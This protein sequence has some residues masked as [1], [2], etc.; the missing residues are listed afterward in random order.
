MTLTTVLSAQVTYSGLKG[1]LHVYDADTIYPGLLYFNAVYSGFTKKDTELKN[2]I[3]DNTLNIAL[4]FGLSHSFEFF[5]HFVPYQDDQIGYWGP[6][7]DSRLGLKFHA[8]APKGA[9]FYF[10]MFAYANFPTGYRHNLMFEPF[11]TDKKGW[12]LGGIG[13]FDLKDRSNTLPVKF[14]INIGYRDHD[15][16]DRYFTDKKD[17]FVGGLGIKFPV[18]SSILYSEFTGRIFINNLEHVDFHQNLLRYTQGFRFLGPFNVIFDV[19]ADIELGGY[20]P[21]EHER[22]DPFLK[23]YA[24]WKVYVGVSYSI[25]VFEY[26]TREERLEKKHYRKET[27]KLDAVKDK[28]E[29]VIK[30]LEDL[31][32]KLEKEKQ[33]EPE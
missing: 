10:G 12:M 19:A 28:R 3:E 32:E 6:I 8:P 30:E 9:T 20:R 16:D 24:D 22:T 29:N 27:Q 4:T 33:P 13:T 11:T 23:D 2:L 1:L 14:S 15:W 25:E 18:R 17:Q 7:G 21:K 31:R 26:L 5:G